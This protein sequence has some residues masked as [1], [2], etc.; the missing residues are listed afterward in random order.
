MKQ[1]EE[2]TMASP[3]S[4]VAPLPAARPDGGAR[5]NDFSIQVATANGSGSQSSNTVLLRAIF[6]M[7]VPVSGKNLFPSNIAG[8]PTWY[9]IRASRDGW[10]ARKKE[11]D[12]LVAMNPE[13]ARDD[14]LGLSAGAAVVYDAP[15][16]LAEL[17]PDLVYYP[18]AFDALVEPLTKE[19]KLRRLLRNMAYVGVLARLLDLD[20]GEVE[21]A[22][23]KQ[24][25]GK[26]RARDLNVAAARAGFDHAATLEKRDPLV[27][28][29]MDRTAGKILVD[30]NAAAAMGALFAG[31]TVVAWYPITPSSS[32]VE[33][34]IG[35]L[36]RYRIG[37]DGKA[38]FAV[39]QAED[40]LAAVGMAIGAGWA[41]ARAMTATAGPGVSLMSEFAGLAYYAEIPAVIFD[42]QRVGPSTGLPTR[43]AQGD[44]LSTAFL[45]HGDTRHVLLFPGSVEECFTMGVDAFDLAERLQTP[46]F[47]MTDLD[48][49]MNVWMSDPFPYPARPLDRGKVLGKDDLDRLG[50]FARYA[51]VDGD[52]IGWRTLPGTPHPKAAYFTRGTGHDE[53]AAY[54]EDPR[55][56]ERNLARLEKKLDGARDLLPAPVR[57]GSGE[58]KLGLLAYGSSDPALREARDQLR[59]EAGLDS[60][61]LR[62]RAYPF[63][64]EVREFVEAHERVYVVEQ[65]RDG[66]LAALL[67][68]DLPAALV[69]RL[70]PVPHLDGLPLDAR[71]VSDA[72]R[73]EEAR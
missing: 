72:I 60:D 10:I 20:L 40:E 39:V 65:N 29:R 26:P 25:P 1:M 30:G 58:A 36:R 73:A 69:P 15:L 52:G 57:E 51:D 34:L 16:A 38:T 2:R 35:H 13:T 64:R 59:R 68:L 50:G 66:Q 71:T 23:E 27:V 5:V 6:Q 55:T 56:F 7:G 17:R 48:L 12:L 31:V 63:S 14:V 9:T 53:Q 42:V 22:I 67:K 49:G 32:L 54:S 8:L 70:R 3:D 47:V 61:Y 18:V 33:T 41:G 24:F 37:P 11:V 46:V 62:V 45:S 21:H 28:R 4:S 43:T 44:V 19:P